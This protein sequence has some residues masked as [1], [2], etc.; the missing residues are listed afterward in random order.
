MM[1]DIDSLNEEEKAFLDTYTQHYTVAS[2]DIE[3]D[4][5]NILRTALKIYDQQSIMNNLLVKILDEIR[6]LRR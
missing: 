3:E 5:K 6:G 4:A 2:P 1:S